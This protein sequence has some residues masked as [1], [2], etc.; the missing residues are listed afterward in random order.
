AGAT[1]HGH[2]FD[3]HGYHIF[4]DWYRNAQALAKELGISANFAD[5]IDF[6]Q[7]EADA[8]PHF[9]NYQNITSA[10]FAIKNIFAGVL[11]VCEAVLLYYAALDLM[12]Q[13]YSY[14]AQLDQITVTGFLHSRLYRTDR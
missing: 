11:P 9:K 5:C 3:E 10:R 6:F 7:L 13:P 1:K 8:F 4:P 12:S 14:R 2:D